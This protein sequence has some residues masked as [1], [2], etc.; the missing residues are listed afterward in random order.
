[1][2][3]RGWGGS[4]WSGGARGAPGA[5]RIE[6][7]AGPVALGREGGGEVVLPGQPVLDDRARGTGGGRR[8]ASALVDG[9]QLVVEVEQAL[10]ERG[11]G[12]GEAHP[13][14]LAGEGEVL[15]VQVRCAGRAGLDHVLRVLERGDAVRGVQADPDV[16]GVELLDDAEE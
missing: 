10:A 3:D 1:G 7:A 2:W 12:V 4:G 15:H 13:A 8:G 5:Q 6:G 14:L 11:A 9:G 16:R